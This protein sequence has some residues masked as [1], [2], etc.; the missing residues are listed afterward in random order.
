MAGPDQSDQPAL[1]LVNLDKPTGRSSAAAV[2]AVRAVL[3]GR[4]GPRVG[5]AG[6]LDPAARGV[7]VLLVGRATRLAELLM[8]A[9]KEYVAGVRLGATSTTDDAEGEIREMSN[10]EWRMTNETGQAP[11][12][13]QTQV[14]PPDEQTVR[15]ALGRFV[16]TIRQ[17]PPD[18]SAVHVAGRRA[19]RLARR[20]AAVD[21]PE[22]P[23]R[24]DAIELLDYAWPV[25][26]I[27]VACGRGT[28]IRSLARDLGRALGVG[29][30]LASL[31]RT[32]VGPFR[33]ADAVSPEACRIETLGEWLL[34][35]ESA[36]VGLP[37][38]PRLELTAKQVELLSRGAGL[39][40][41]RV[42]DAARLVRAARQEG[43]PPPSGIDP[44]ARAAEG[45]HP[46]IIEP[47]AAFD[48]SGRLVALCRLASGELRSTAMIRPSR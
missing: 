8:D 34:P 11:V 7:L 45:A 6:T 44:P 46:V 36:I 3:G 17:R 27:R 47:I 2:A 35:A 24:I 19:Y 18:Y 31:T 15:E 32:R 28:Y 25:L 26:R 9:G 29:G 23:V 1:G 33:I 43:S 20:G 5:H 4:R 12:E 41:A 38:L 48:S 13:R 39:D 37:A 22:R 21:L 40:P 10:D 16:G 14:R 42:P 30:Y